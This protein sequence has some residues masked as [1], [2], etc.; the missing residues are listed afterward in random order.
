VTDSVPSTTVQPKRGSCRRKRL[1]A[2]CKQEPRKCWHCDN[3]RPVHYW[4]SSNR[5][6]CI[7]CYQKYVN[8]EACVLCGKTK[9]VRMRDE[10]GGAVC[11]ACYQRIRPSEICSC[12]HEPGKIVERHDNGRRICNRCYQR[13]RRHA[14]KT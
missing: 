7:I 1:K 4:K 3:V 9:T 13:R 6:I 11:H 2:G 14:N 10:N 5:P 12:C 8:V